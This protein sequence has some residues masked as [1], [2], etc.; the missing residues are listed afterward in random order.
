MKRNQ[1]RDRD[2]YTRCKH[3]GQ[4]WP[5]E[6]CTINPVDGSF[7]CPAGCRETF[8]QPEYESPFNGQ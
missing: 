3:C 6:Q 8:Q 1:L 7:M 5:E 2:D 4:L